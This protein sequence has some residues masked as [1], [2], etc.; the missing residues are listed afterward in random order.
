MQGLGVCIAKALNH[1]MEHRG[2]VF[3]DHYHSRLLRT[4]TE[5]VNAIAYVLG[6]AAHHFGGEPGRDPF[7]SGAYD[8]CARKRILA[9]PIGWL[10]GPGGAAR[11]G[12]PGG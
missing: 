4:P 9:E 10:C 12:S 5:L 3:D 8:D 6:N 2:A 11:Q 7:S 1:L